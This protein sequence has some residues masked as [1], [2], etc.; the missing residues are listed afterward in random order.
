MTFVNSNKYKK[1]N[2]N[3]LSGSL[4]FKYLNMSKVE[5]HKVTDEAILFENIGRLRDVKM[6]NDGYIYISVE[7][8][9]TIYRLKTKEIKKASP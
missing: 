3:I 1:W 6:G 2:G 5:G 7:N 9:G 4:R 8:P